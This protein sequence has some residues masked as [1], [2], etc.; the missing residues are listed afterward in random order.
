MFIIKEPL[1]INGIT[2]NPPNPEE[3]GNLINYF[4]YIFPIIIISF[5]FIISGKEKEKTSKE[6]LEQKLIK[7]IEN[8]KF[9][10]QNEQCWESL[11]KFINHR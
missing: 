2:F 7:N 1:I 5:S 11:S 3:V 6:K 9:W 4:L 8:D 10:N